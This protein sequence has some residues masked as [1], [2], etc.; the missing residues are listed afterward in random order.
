L[1][2]ILSSDKMLKQKLLPNIKNNNA[3]FVW[4]VHIFCALPFQVILGWKGK[5]WIEEV[6]LLF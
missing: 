3:L 4:N 1:L 5:L 6:L 2:N